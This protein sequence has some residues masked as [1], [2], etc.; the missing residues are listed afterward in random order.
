MTLPKESRKLIFIVVYQKNSSI[1]IEIKDSGGGIE[2][3][4]IDKIFEPYFTTKH[5]SLGTGI[6]LYMTQS[7]ITK[8]LNGEIVVQNV[9]Y[10]YESEEYCGAEFRIVLNSKNSDGGF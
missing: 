6:G 10:E 4:I 3:D 7:I 2:E 9:D 1:I 8:H 5:K